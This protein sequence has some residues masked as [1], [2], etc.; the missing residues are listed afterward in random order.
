MPGV[1]AAEAE[2]F[3]VMHRFAQEFCKNPLDALRAQDYFAFQIEPGSTR[4]RRANPEDAV[5]LTARCAAGLVWK[6]RRFRDSVWKVQYA[7][8]LL[9]RQ[10]ES[11]S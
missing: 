5:G 10:I 6:A 9:R 2:F 1:R 8:R 7:S 11:R 4:A 3:T